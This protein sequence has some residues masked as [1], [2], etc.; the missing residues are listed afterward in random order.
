MAQHR[1]KIIIC[2]AC[3]RSHQEWFKISTDQ[4]AL[5]LSNW[6]DLTKRESLY[7]SNR[8]LTVRWRQR[9]ESF[10]GDITARALLDVLDAEAVSKQEEETVATVQMNL[11]QGDSE[12]VTA[13][14]AL[15]LAQQDKM[16]T[17]FHDFMSLLAINEDVD[18][19]PSHLEAPN[20]EVLPS[21]STAVDLE[22]PAII[23]TVG[24]Y[25]KWS[26]LV[27]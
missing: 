7:D 11:N 12:C 10:D 3:K 24:Y 22:I 17:F 16:L 23:A 14:I 27:L 18:A 1:C 13:P 2:T 15:D 5:V 9:I 21:P 8:T 19:V 26:N 20:R 4:A 25:A 6:S